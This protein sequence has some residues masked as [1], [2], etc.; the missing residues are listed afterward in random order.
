MLLQQCSLSSFGEEQFLQT[1]CVVLMSPV[2]LQPCIQSTKNKRLR[3]ATLTYFFGFLR[4][5]KQFFLCTRLLK[6]LNE[7]FPIIC[8]HQRPLVINR[9]PAH[10]PPLRRL[11]SASMPTPWRVGKWHTARAG[12]RNFLNKALSSFSVSAAVM[13]WCLNSNTPKLP[14]QAYESLQALQS[15]P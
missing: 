3:Q 2:H 14:P 8:S 11:P 12:A 5:L 13:F 6:L 9:E 4:L 1:N 10:L 7:F 15:L